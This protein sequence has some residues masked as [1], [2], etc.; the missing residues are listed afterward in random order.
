MTFSQATTSQARTGPSQTPDLLLFFVNSLLPLP[1]FFDM[2]M[3]ADCIVELPAKRDTL[4]RAHSLALQ[5]EGSS[6][7][8]RE[9]LVIELESGAG[10]DSER[11]QDCLRQ[12]LK[13][14]KTLGPARLFILE[15]DTLALEAQNMLAPLTA[16]LAKLD[17]HLSILKTR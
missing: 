15:R 16:A 2:P 6:L 8:R 10:E 14:V 1:E 7:K 5:A 11:A 4:R 17:L 3:P 13:A 9:E 12:T